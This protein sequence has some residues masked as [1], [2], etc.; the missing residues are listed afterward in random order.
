MGRKLVV[1][2]KLLS[3]KIF[4]GAVITVFATFAALTLTASPAS[5][6]TAPCGNAWFDYDVDNAWK[7]YCPDWAPNGQIPVHRNQLAGAPIVGYIN[8]AGQ[9]W[10]FCQTQGVRYN[11]N[12]YWNTWWAYTK[13]DNGV[14]GYVNQVYFQGGG[15][16]ERDGNLRQ[17]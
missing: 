5:A 4:Q 13:A 1:Q 6:D 8:A 17:C 7:A 9:D 10:Y 15:N 12:S 3:R 14:R 2:I 11:L 16:N